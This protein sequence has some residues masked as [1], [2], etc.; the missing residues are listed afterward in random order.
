MTSVGIQ[1]YKIKTRI[2]R[3]PKYAPWMER[4]GLLKSMDGLAVF[5]LSYS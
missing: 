2:K 3:I 1:Q 4:G 5:C